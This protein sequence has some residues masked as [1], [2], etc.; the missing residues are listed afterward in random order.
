MSRL[1][2]ARNARPVTQLSTTHPTGAR[3]EALSDA[4]LAAKRS[5][6]TLI[7]HEIT[8]GRTIAGVVALA[9]VMALVF[10]L[11]AAA[12]WGQ[13]PVFAILSG[14]SLAV[15]ITYALAQ[16]GGAGRLVALSHERAWSQSLAL[17]AKRL[18][19]AV[20]ATD[21]R[22]NPLG[23]EAIVN[24]QIDALFKELER[25]KQRLVGAGADQP[26]SEHRQHGRI[27]PVFS[28]TVL[29]PADGRRYP[30]RIAGLSP[31]GVTL[32]GVV[33]SLRQAEQVQIGSRQ[34]TVVSI[35]AREI[36]LRFVTPVLPAEFNARIVL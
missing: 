10:G 21:G 22:G 34:A 28:E 17:H 14:L 26:A 24:G 1:S 8:R 15:P 9:G 23:P 29:V 27:V 6:D 18:G 36:A 12:G 2:L 31:L 33:P 11:A 16:A 19:E 30:V 20:G 13:A 3:C 35:G 32:R 7:E 5:A 4:A 25:T